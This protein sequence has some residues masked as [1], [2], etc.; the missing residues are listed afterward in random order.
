MVRGRK[1]RNALAANFL[2]PIY[3]IY[4]FWNNESNAKTKWTFSYFRRRSNILVFAQTSKNGSKLVLLRLSLI[5][6]KNEHFSTFW[7]FESRCID[8]LFHQ[9]K[10]LPK[11]TFILVKCRIVKN[12]HNV[13][14]SKK[15]AV[16]YK[17]LGT[18]V[19]ASCFV[20]VSRFYEIYHTT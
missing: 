5:F 16:F 4:V 3:C 8:A 1:K 2:L 20:E 15:R 17:I 18:K 19:K 12:I 7:R 11:A 6:D 10:M 9:T 13:G 14:K